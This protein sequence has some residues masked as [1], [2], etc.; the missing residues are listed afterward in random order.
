MNHFLSVE[1]CPNPLGWA[2][3]A[4][5]LKEHPFQDKLFG[6]NKTLG[7][8]FFN[9]SLRTRLSMTRAAQ[10]LG[11]QTISLNVSTDGLQLEMD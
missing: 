1:D 6:I 4:I 9:S 10:N 8:V 2:H 11:M 7:L 5:K 3:E